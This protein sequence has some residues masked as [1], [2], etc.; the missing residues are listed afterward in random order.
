MKDI[1]LENVG[2][3]LLT[4]AFDFS[5][6]WVWARGLVTVKTNRNSGG[7][8]CPPHM[9][10]LFSLPQFLQLPPQPAESPN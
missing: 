9:K 1:K 7:Q 2:L 3:T 4:A 6:F 8:E 5:F 10:V